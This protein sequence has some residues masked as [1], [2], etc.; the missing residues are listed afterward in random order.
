MLLKKPIQNLRRGHIIEGKTGV[1]RDLSRLQSDVY[2]IFYINSLISICEKNIYLLL[3]LFP[4]ATIL[5]M[6]ICIA[7]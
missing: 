7:K 1:T 6:I 3:L 4:L 5:K 2:V